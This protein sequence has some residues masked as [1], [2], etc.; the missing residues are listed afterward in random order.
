EYSITA[1]AYN[2]GFTSL[3]SFIRMFKIVKGVTPSE[4]RSM[5]RK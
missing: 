1:V 2:S 4:F 5:Y 3:S